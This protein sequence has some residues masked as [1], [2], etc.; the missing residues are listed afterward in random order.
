MSFKAKPYTLHEYRIGFEEKP[1]L[2]PLQAR[3]LNLYYKDGSC[4]LLFE[5]PSEN[6]SD[7]EMRKF[8]ICET[9][10]QIDSRYKYVGTFHIQPPQIDE[11]SY[12][13]K[14]TLSY[15]VFEV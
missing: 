4:Y 12:K 1:I 3:L 15:H 8:K 11:V 7:A 5:F 13:I 6:I 9:G 14:K 2:V 10:T